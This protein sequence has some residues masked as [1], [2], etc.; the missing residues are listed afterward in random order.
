MLTGRSSKKGTMTQMIMGSVRIR[1]LRIRARCVST[2][3]TRL[4][5]M[6]HGMR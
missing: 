1:W 6:N 4:N 5:S 2:S 3:P